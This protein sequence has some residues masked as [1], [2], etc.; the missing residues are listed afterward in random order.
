TKVRVDGEISDIVPKMQVDRYKI[1]DIEIVI[2]RLKVSQE[3]RKRLYTSVLQAM[4]AA[5]GIIKISNRENT[6]EQFFSRYLMDAESGISYDEPQPNTFSFNSPYGACPKCDGLGYI[7]E[8]DK[9]IVIPDRKISIQKGAIAPL[10]PLRES[11]NSAILKAV[12]HKFDFSLAAPI[13]KLSEELIDTLL[14]GSE[15][16]I[17]LTVSYGAYGA[18]EYRVNF[19]G[20]LKMLEEMSGKQNDDSPALEDF[21]TKVCCPSC[22]GARLKQES[23]HF[24]IDGKNISELAAM[25]ISTLMEWLVNLETRM[26]ERQQVIAT[27]I[28]KEIRARLGFLL[29]VGLNYLTLDRSSKTLSGGEAQRIRL[30]TQ[31]GS[32]LVNVLYIL[33]EPS[34][35][36]H[37]RD[38]ERLISSLKNLRDIGNSVLVVEHDK[39]MILN[40]DY[41]IDMG[42]AAGING[43]KVVAKGTPKDIVE[44]DTL[45]AAY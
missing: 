29:D 3:D 17:P 1:H 39:D 25:D 27:E 30:A 8:I 11:W 41:V 9:N 32:Q 13:E 16:P 5:K 24:K 22:Q 37:Q 2:D 34:I 38:N 23:L 36:L 21:R 7:F 31:I 44:A 43:G 45:T 4:K 28:L 20:L 26:D 10:G 12:A 35:G 18:R 42:P 33:D 15:E 6:R 40:A 14:F 19:S